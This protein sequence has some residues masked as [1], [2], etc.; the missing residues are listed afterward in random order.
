MIPCQEF[1]TISTVVVSNAGYHIRMI[2]PPL[3]TLSRLRKIPE[4]L[5]VTN[6]G[7]YNTAMIMKTLVIE[8]PLE[9]GLRGNIAMDS[10]GQ[11]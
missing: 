9:E 1:S 4:G 10:E 2:K 5:V 8:R 6:R 7:T 3:S 11:G